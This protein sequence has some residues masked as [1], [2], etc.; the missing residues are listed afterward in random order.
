MSQ[1][2]NLTTNRI[3][4]DSQQQQKIADMTTRNLRKTERA[5]F[6]EWSQ[7]THSFPPCLNEYKK[8]FDGHLIYLS[9]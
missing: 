6:K 4:R 2:K 3:C 8:L 5:G 1:N 7:P 9:P